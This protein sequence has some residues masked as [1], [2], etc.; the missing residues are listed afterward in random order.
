M[1]FRQILILLIL[2]ITVISCQNQ[3]S[4]KKNKSTS[5]VISDKDIDQKK[6]DEKLVKT[7][8]VWDS[9]SEQLRNKELN[10]TQEDSLRR[11]FNYNKKQQE[12]IFQNFIRQN[13]NSLVS[14][15]TLNGFKFSW[16]K[17]LTEKL[18][19]SLNT[20]IQSSEKGDQVKEYIKYYRNPKIS[21]KYSDFTLP[22]TKGDSIQLAENL[23]D[24]TLLEFWA[25]WCSGCR[26]E[27]PKLIQVYEKYKDRKFTVIGISSDSSQ[28]IWLNAIEKDQLPWINLIDSNG[29]ESIVQYKYGIH[30]IPMNFLIGPNKEIIAKDIKPKELDKLL[31]K[32]LRKTAHNIG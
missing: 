28:E 22:N 4:D 7:N 21:D 18:F 15:E 24:Y 11:L 2:T 1:N 3:P 31:E 19:K 10:K 13:P 14:I 8:A 5:S 17:D 27:H 23:S 6:L 16:G 32:E 30:F 12:T 20:E 26:E 25:S 29:R 9:L